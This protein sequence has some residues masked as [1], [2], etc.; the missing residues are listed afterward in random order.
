MTTANTPFPQAT[1]EGYPRV[2]AQRELKK[3]L[4]AFWSGKIDQETFESAAHSLRVDTY[5]RLKDLGLNE[6]YAI[7]AD[8]AL[9]DQVLETS[10]TVGVVGGDAAEVSLEEEF[11]LA[12]GNAERAPLEMTKWFDTNYHYIVPEIADEQKFIARPQRVVRLVE[13]ARA[14][15]H[16]VRPYLVGPVTVLALSKQAEGSTGQPLARLDELV[17]SYIQVLA[18]LAD[19]GVEWVQLAEPATVA[20]LAVADD[21]QIAAHLEAAYTRILAAE[22]RPQ[23]YL[24]TPYGSARAGLEV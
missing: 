1:I 16:A 9:Y 15:G 5:A 2:G 3:A 4:E 21:V 10:L 19:A 12:R 11:A 6:D 24:T 22:N 14:Q 17:D 7:P 18:A 23:V 8:V 13:E 20:D